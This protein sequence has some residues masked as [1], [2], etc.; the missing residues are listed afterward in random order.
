MGDRRQG[1]PQI[2]DSAKVLGLT[3]VSIE[4]R[5]APETPYPGPVEEC[6]RGLQWTADDLGIDGARIIVVGESAGGG[7][8]AAMAFLS[9]DRGGPA[10][11]GLPLMAPMLDD[12]NDSPS[13][14][15]MAGTDT[16]DRSRNEFG[17]S[18]FTGYRAGRSGRH[19]VRGARSRAETNFDR[20]PPVFLDVGSAETFRDEV[21]NFASSIWRA[22]GRAELDVWP[23]GFHGYNALAPE[24]AISRGTHVARARWLERLSGPDWPHVA[25]AP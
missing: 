25:T 15:Q 22:G 20:L 2:L 9:R 7:L 8:A 19:G 12:R 3:V 10:A 16:W 6:Y 14:V 13:A 18:A 5:L 21:I 24:A 23:G 11:I 1:L 4:Y 17:W